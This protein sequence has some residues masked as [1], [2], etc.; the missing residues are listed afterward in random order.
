MIPWTVADTTP[1]NLLWNKAISGRENNST[2]G[3]VSASL[4]QRAA[5]RA[6]AA[7]L[8]FDARRDARPPTLNDRGEPL[9]P[10]ARS[11]IRLAERQGRPMN[12]QPVGRARSGFEDFP[13]LVDVRFVELA[14]VE[15]RF[16]PGPHG[17]I[18][19]RIYTPSHAPSLP[20]LVW[21][22][23]GGFVVG[24]LRSHDRVLRHIAKESGAIVVAVDYRL[25]PE[26]RFPVGHE[27]AVAAARWV[28]A[29]ARAIGGD[30]N[31]VAIGGDSAGGNLTASTCISLRDL[32]G[33]VPAFQVL[34]Y[35]ATDL[36]R[37]SESH[38]TLATGYLLTTE[39]IT[40]FMTL[41]LRGK[42]DESNAIGSPLL[43]KDLSRLPPAF[44]VT[45]GFDPLRDEGEAYAARLRESGVRVETRCESSL[46][47][48]YLSMGGVIP[49]AKDAV[50]AVARAV[51]RGLSQTVPTRAQE[52]GDRSEK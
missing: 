13:P 35:P 3:R 44:L 25:G 8:A 41:Y 21:F 51:A 29:N 15:D 4:V 46:F 5:R 39:L 50:D 20:I 43:A 32:G 31:R 9:D 33:P 1:S 40:W 14:R 34:V 17:E 10:I 48:G 19:V 28:L 36:R 6:I 22:H 42:D 24:S 27:D 38:R 18:P 37:A 23:G 52:A 16:V 30:P 7:F 26:H 49:A 2:L 47:H 11:L 12:E 45:A